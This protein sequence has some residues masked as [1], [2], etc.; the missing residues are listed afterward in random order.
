VA[1][2]SASGGWSSGGALMVWAGAVVIEMIVVLVVASSAGDDS[3]VFGRTGTTIVVVALM[4]L[5][6]IAAVYGWR[7]VSG[8][9]SVLLACGQFV[10]AV[11]VLVMV[12]GFLNGDGTTA[13][14]V[15]P[16][17]FFCVLAE[18]MIGIGVL[19]SARRSADSTRG[20]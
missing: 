3:L 20:R 14:S 7:G 16:L 17:L 5:A 12:L 15:T 11:L 9:R 19:H 6:V 18:A 4:A 1:K 10:G 8:P 2:S 13:S